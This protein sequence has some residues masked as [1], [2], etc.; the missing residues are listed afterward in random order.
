MATP[1]PAGAGTPCPICGQPAQAGFKP[2]CCDRC[3]LR[4]LAHWIG[5]DEPYAIPGRQLLPGEIEGVLR[6]LHVQHEGALRPLHVQ[7]EG[8]LLSDEAGRDDEP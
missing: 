2:F 8:A 5:G 7:H 6:P 1:S 3:R 4:D